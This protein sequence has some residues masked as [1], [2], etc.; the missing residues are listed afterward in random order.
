MCSQHVN[1][2]NFV[3]YDTFYKV[4]GYKR[5]YK[6][7]PLKQVNEDWK[8]AGTDCY[9]TFN[10]NLVDWGKPQSLTRRFLAWCRG[11]AIDDPAPGQFL[12]QVRRPVRP[13]KSV[14]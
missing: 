9:Y 5:D 7:G 3:F 4:T 1:P 13:G 8:F 6:G 2:T 14:D 12:I 11:I 10:P